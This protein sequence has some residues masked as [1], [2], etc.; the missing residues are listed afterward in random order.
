MA[1]DSAERQFCSIIF[2][3]SSD[4]LRLAAGELKRLLELS[5]IAEVALLRGEGDP[6]DHDDGRAVAVEIST[7]GA[8]PERGAFSIRVQQNG[9]GL[10]IRLVGSDEV[11]ALY[12]VYELLERLGY[13]FYPDRDV[14]PRSISWHQVE[15]LNVQS[16]PSINLRGLFVIPAWDDLPMYAI[17]W[18]YDRWEQLVDWMAKQ[19][20]NL[21]RLHLFPS[22]G[23]FPLRKY[24]GTRPAQRNSDEKI[25][26]MK[27]VI[28][29]AQERGIRVSLSLY[30]NGVTREFAQTYPGTSYNAWYTYF[31]RLDTEVG[32][33]YSLTSVREMIEEYQPDY[34]ELVTT[35]VHDPYREWDEFSQDQIR[36]FRESIQYIVSTGTSVAVLPFIFPV[37]YRK[38]MELIDAPSD[39][40]L[41]TETPEVENTDHY[42]AGGHYIACFEENSIPFMRFKI[43][44]VGTYARRFAEKG[45]ALTYYLTGFSTKNFEITATAAAKQFWSPYDFDREAFLQQAVSHRIA[46]VQSDHGRRLAESLSRFERAWHKIES[47]TLA[48]GERIFGLMPSLA[49]S[50]YSVFLETYAPLLLEHEDEIQASLTHALEAIH[51]LQ[52]AKRGF[53]YPLEVEQLELHQHL[54]YLNYLSLLQASKAFVNHRQVQMNYKENLWGLHRESELLSEE[55]YE[56]MRKAVA[57]L[58]ELVRWVEKDP[59]Y[60]DVE[61][62]YLPYQDPGASIYH[63][64][65]GF[66][67]NVMRHRL[68]STLALLD[69]IRALKDKLVLERTFQGP[70]RPFVIPHIFES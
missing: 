32:W 41:F 9:Q 23:F 66:T 33:D 50:N 21:L 40:L 7:E 63:R 58:E 68:Q 42:R 16:K 44:E 48:N 57:G 38:L 8:T 15:N 3:P 1:A 56:W 49:N 19:K 36:L 53:A 13:G 20:M 4:G 60:H 62:H 27:R 61:P 28:R 51:L 55:A 65:A 39:T 12:A 11:G 6:L 24:R 26:I 67:L 25:S 29:R 37:G 47:I 35:E 54:F 2:D 18:K 52:S 43:D 31:V 17:Y 5:D 46:P 10:D 45:Y 14:I 70:H 64:H 30:P 34:V 69:E 59:D 22:M